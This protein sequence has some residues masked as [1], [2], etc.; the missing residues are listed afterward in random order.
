M[1][2]RNAKPI[3]VE[4]MNAVKYCVH[5]GELMWI[6]TGKGRR[7]DRRIISKHYKTGH[8][9]VS[10]MSK[11]Y[12]VHRV[13]W[14]LFFGS[15][16]DGVEIDHRDGNPANN[17]LSN[18]RSSDS[19]QNNCNSR[20]KTKSAHGLKGVGKNGKG[21][22][23]SIMKNGQKHYLGTYGSPEEAH[24]VYAKAAAVLH[25]EFARAA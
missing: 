18:L 10:F 19:S 21:W 22:F 12:L 5:S 23:A 4:L 11:K 3:P 13:I 9:Y 14:T 25:G 15:I 8:L 1:K 2:S 17:E 24:S 20:T 6:T 16:A 7:K